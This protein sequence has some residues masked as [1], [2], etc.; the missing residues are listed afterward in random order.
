M[1]S[2][3]TGDKG[4]YALWSHR[5]MEQHIVVLKGPEVTAGFNFSAKI[6]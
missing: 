3:K 1:A 2:R 5:E 6:P 4:P